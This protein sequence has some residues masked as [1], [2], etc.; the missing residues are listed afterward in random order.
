MFDKRATQLLI[1]LCTS[2]T[3]IAFAIYCRHH[4]APVS[5]TVLY[6]A[7]AIICL[8]GEGYGH[9]RRNAC[10]TKSPIR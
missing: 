2:C 9:L 8:A 10:R 5:R 6:V 1:A 7:A 4:L 3:L